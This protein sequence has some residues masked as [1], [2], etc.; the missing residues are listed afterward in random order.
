M[1]NKG[2]LPCASSQKGL[3]S[4]HKPQHE[5]DSCCHMFGRGSYLPQLGRTPGLTRL[6]DPGPCHI[7]LWGSHPP[8][9]WAKL[10]GAQKPPLVVQKGPLGTRKA[11]KLAQGHI[12]KTEMGGGLGSSD[13]Q[14]NARIAVEGS[15][16]SVRWQ[17]AWGWEG[18]PVL[19][20][21]RAKAEW[22]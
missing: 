3:A 8:G 21:G 20:T 16:G 14:M 18:G 15:L 13:L 11:R 22:G 9:A 10:T 12:D 1:R 6:P 7:P 4:P 5:T 17:L 2:F 19:G